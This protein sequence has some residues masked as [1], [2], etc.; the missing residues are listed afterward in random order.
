[1]K[2]IHDANIKRSKKK[3]AC[4]LRIEQCDDVLLRN[5]KVQ[6]RIDFI[7]I[8]NEILIQHYVNTSFV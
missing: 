2:T 1:M 8:R 6:S 7:I 5:C 3:S 4:A